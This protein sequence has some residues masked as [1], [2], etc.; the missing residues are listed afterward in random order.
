[1]PE[2]FLHGP[3]VRPGIEQVGREAVAQRVYAIS[4]TLADRAQEPGDR[5]LHTTGSAASSKT[6]SFHLNSARP[7]DAGKAYY[8]AFSQLSTP[9][10]R[11]PDGRIIRMNLDRFVVANVGGVLAPFWNG[12]T[13]IG[14]LDS[15]GRA[16]ARLTIPGVI[17]STGKFTFYAAFLTLDP[18]APSGIGTVSNVV[19]FTTNL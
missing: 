12:G 3:Q 17:P 14:L 13:N 5:P 18:N 2:Q 19:P 4:R 9:G 15:S 8:L 7:G 16:T 11:L 1:M 10:A 6:L